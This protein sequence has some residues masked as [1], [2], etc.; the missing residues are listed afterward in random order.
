MTCYYSENFDR[1]LKTNFG[2]IRTK[3][4]QLLKSTPPIEWS[5]NFP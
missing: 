5:G 4:V 1:I 3:L 2:T